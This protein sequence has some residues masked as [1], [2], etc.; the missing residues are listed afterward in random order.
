MSPSSRNIIELN[1]VI[2]TVSLKMRVKSWYYH[3]KL[4]LYSLTG[5]GHILHTLFWSHNTIFLVI[6]FTVCWTHRFHDL[7]SC[8]RWFEFGNRT[9]CCRCGVVCFY[10]WIFGST[11]ATASSL[12]GKNNAHSSG[13]SPS[14][15][16]ERTVGDARI[17]T[18]IFFNFP[19]VALFTF[20]IWIVFKCYEFRE[21]YQ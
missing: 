19:L 11:F 1:E 21:I 6:C 12:A 2:F 17:A 10:R 8:T 4:S 9:G 5:A 14:Y 18:A 16:T 7:A 13:A 3:I 15:S 20:F